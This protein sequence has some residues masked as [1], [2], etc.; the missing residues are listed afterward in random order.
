[1]TL[2]VLY[3]FAGVTITI[4]KERK[5]FLLMNVIILFVSVCQKFYPIYIIKQDPEFYLKYFFRHYPPFAPF[6]INLPE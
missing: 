3:L 2:F 1:M 5:L 6:L 4:S